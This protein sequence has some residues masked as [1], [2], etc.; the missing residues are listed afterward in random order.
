MIVAM[1]LV[2]VMQMTVDEVVDMVAVRHRG[3]T[4]RGAVHVIG[5]V[6]AAPMT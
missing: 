2:G 5:G 6:S 3:V 4:A 1:T